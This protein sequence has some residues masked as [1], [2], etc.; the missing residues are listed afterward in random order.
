MLQTGGYSVVFSGDLGNRVTHLP[1][2]QSPP[3]ADLLFLESTYGGTHSHT[4]MGDARSDLF[5]AVRDA[6]ENGE[7]VLIPTL[8]VGRAQLLQLLFKK[9]FMVAA[10]D[11]PDRAQLVVDGMA[12]EATEIYHQYTTADTYMDES[13][14]NR[15]T[16]SEWD[17]PFRPTGTVFPQ[18]DAKRR[19][20]LQ[21]VN[22][23]HGGDRSDHHLAVG[24]ADRRKFL[25]VSRRV[26]RSVRLREGV[27]H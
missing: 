6:V 22:P 5:D 25:A 3:E 14:V 8:T 18:S 19:E 26:R 27:P 23:L 9:R 13:I 17:E 2:L 15:V 24:D 12:Q 16:D 4:S 1:S 11:F 10:D 7:P 21:D 20:V